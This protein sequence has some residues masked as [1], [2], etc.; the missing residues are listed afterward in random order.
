MVHESTSTLVPL[1]ILEISMEQPF[2][3]RF[4]QRDRPRN[5]QFSMLILLKEMHECF[6][7]RWI[8]SVKEA[9][10]LS[11]FILPSLLLFPFLPPSEKNR[12]RCGIKIPIIFNRLQ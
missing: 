5:V 7:Y 8:T 11:L 6:L 3:N 10:P 2:L 12:K 4:C 1:C 9:C